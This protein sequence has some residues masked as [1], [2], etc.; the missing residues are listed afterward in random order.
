M[1]NSSTN[2]PLKLLTKILIRY[3]FVIFVV[4]VGGALV[5]SVIIANDILNQPFENT[6]NSNNV[7]KTFDQDTISRLGPYNIITHN[8]S[9]QT[10]PTGRIN[11]FSE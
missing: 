3:N 4:L 11:P 1:K 2:N 5:L 10:I 8:N 6:V 7:A 9:D